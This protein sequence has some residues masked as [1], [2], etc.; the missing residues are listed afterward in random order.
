MQVAGL[1]DQPDGLLVEADRAREQLDVG[2]DVVG[3]LAEVGVAL[4]ER[5]VQHGG[6]QLRG[7]VAAGGLLAVHVL[8]GE[9]QRVRRVAWL[10]AG[11]RRLRRR[12]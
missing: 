2:G 10:R 1:D 12:R 7:A 11:S 4:G 9:P 8:V 5:G 6:D 3:V